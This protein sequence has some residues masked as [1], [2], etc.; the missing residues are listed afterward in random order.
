CAAVT[1][2]LIFL[3]ALRGT[4]RNRSLKNVIVSVML[5][6]LVCLTGLYY[7]KLPIDVF[8]R[9]NML[10]FFAAIVLLTMV[11]INTFK[12]PSEDSVDD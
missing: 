7:N 10:L 1:V 4:L 8:S 5:L 11:A 3:L 2:F 12:K 6:I 9:T